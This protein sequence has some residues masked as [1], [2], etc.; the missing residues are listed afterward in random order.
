MNVKIIII[1]FYTLQLLFMVMR[2]QV[3]SV[4]YGLM[5]KYFC[6]FNKNFLLILTRFQVHCKVEDFFCS[7]FSYCHYNIVIILNVNTIINDKEK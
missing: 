4:K 6:F 5:S 1:T 7:H 2:T 3:I